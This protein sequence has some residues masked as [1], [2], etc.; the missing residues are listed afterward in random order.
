[1]RQVAAG[2]GFTVAVTTEGKVYQMGETGAAGRYKWE[3]AKVPELVS[4][5]CMWRGL[6]MCLRVSSLKLFP[7]AEVVE[8][9]RI[10]SLLSLKEA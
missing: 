10:W 4:W 8:G 1:M 7:N 5:L 6:T 3:G 2:S 9:M